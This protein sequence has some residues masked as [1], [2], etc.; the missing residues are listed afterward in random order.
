MH[1]FVYEDALDTTNNRTKNFINICYEKPHKTQQYMILTIFNSNLHDNK[2]H[3]KLKNMFY[4]KF[5]NRFYA[6][7]QKPKDFQGKDD[8]LVLQPT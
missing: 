6:H 7:A 8:A 4:N 3:Q 1:F 5:D 2:L